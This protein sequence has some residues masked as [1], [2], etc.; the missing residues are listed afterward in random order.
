MKLEQILFSQ[1]FGARKLCRLLIADGDVEVQGHVCTDA[2]AD[3]DVT[4]GAAS[5]DAFEFSVEGVRWQYHAKAY[6]VLNKPA[7]FECSQKPKSHPSV[8]TL[9]PGPLRN[10]DVQ[11]GI[12]LLEL[13]SLR[14][15][16]HAFPDDA[17]A[18]EGG[19]VKHGDEFLPAKAPERIALAQAGG[20][21]P[22]ESRQHRVSG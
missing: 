17:G 4:T 7:D 8:Y 9:L 14:H 20:R 2:A 13:Q 1:G 18:F 21:R 3:Y 5:G 15:R 19:L 10:R 6:L 12:E 22:G 11:A 16:T